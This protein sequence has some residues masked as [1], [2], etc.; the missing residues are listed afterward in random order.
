MQGVAAKSNGP[1]RV[2]K[3]EDE[4]GCAPSCFET[5]RS[6]PRLREQLHSHSAAMLLSMRAW[7]ERSINPQ[8]CEMTAG[9][10]SLFWGCYLQ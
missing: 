6:A 4:P 7:S 8:L 3:D 1:A 2:S 10:I 9:A 5:H